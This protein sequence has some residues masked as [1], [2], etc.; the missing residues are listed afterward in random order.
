MGTS[1]GAARLSIMSDILHSGSEHTKQ[2]HRVTELPDSWTAADGD[3][4]DQHSRDGSREDPPYPADSTSR[5]VQLQQTRTSLETMTMVLEMFLNPKCKDGCGCACHARAQRPRKRSWMSGLAASVGVQ[6]NM[7]SWGIQRDP[8]CRCHGD[9]N[10]EFRSLLWLCARTLVVSGNRQIL[11]SLRARRIIPWSDTYW[12]LLNKS[13]QLVQY[14][15]VLGGT[16]YP[17]DQ[18]ELGHEILVVSDICIIICLC[19]SSRHR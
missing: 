1:Q 14:R 18:T 5:S 9:W 12:R 8:R 7:A 4:A 19:I 16:F 17:D 3:D 2:Q 13:A 15:I 11:V 10:V 6:Y